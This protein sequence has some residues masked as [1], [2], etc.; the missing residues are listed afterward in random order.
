MG[1]G[2]MGN[3]SSEI[4]KALA[5]GLEDPYY[6]ARAASAKAIRLLASGND[7]GMLGELEKMLRGL[8]QDRSFEVKVEALMALGEIS[9][10]PD[11]C[12]DLKTLYF[13]PVWK[14][15]RALF[16]CMT[17]LVQRGVMD[18]D[19]ARGEMDQVLIT[20]YGFVADYPLKKSYNALRQAL[21][22]GSKT[23]G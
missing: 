7:A 13:D 17:R 19:T 6:E 5:S 22:T 16:N 11:L 2:L 12:Q 4:I 1:I 21:N 15:R 14:V 8:V 10:A 18:P 23:E 20:S 3:V 9:Q